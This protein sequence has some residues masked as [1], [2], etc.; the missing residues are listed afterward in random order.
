M[1]L[2]CSHNTFSGPYSSFN[3][4]RQAVAKAAGG[5]FPSHDKDFRV[6]GEIPKKNWWY[7]E[8][9]FTEED[10]P[11]LC[12]FLNHSDCDGEI[13]PEMCG[14]VAKDLSKLKPK[15]EGGEFLF[16]LQRFI[17]GCLEAERR[18]EPVEFC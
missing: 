14:K 16:V 3:R 8:D 9:E 5:S 4:F 6:N 17:K 18:G 7:V 13:S 11:G 15:F 1:G 10:W 2:D 12:E